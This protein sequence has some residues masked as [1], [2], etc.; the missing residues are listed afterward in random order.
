MSNVY[1][2]DN[3]KQDLD[4]KYVAVEIEVGDGQSVVLRNLMRLSKDDRA[5]VVGAIQSLE[6]LDTK[7]PEGLDQLVKNLKAAIG[8]IA[9][10]NGKILTDQIGDDIG[11]LMEIWNLWQNATQL[12]EAEN[13]SA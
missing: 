12:G 1:T 5:K 13:S 11:L 7:T 4:K 6:E 3:L 2:L 10:K 8:V 9:E